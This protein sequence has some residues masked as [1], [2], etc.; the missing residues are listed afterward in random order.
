MWSSTSANRRPT[1]GRGFVNGKAARGIVDGYSPTLYWV[2]PKIGVF[3]LKEGDNTLVAVAL[4]PNPRAEP[5]NTFGLDYLLL[6]R[7]R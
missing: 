3:D 4:E 5:G 6:V 7:Q 1:A 2:H